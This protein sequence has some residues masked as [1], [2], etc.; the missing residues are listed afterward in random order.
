MKTAIVVAFALSACTWD[1]YIAQP[2]TIGS[3]SDPA[4][5]A[6]LQCDRL[7]FAKGSDGHRLC[8]LREI[9]RLAIV[10]KPGYTPITVLPHPYPP[11]AP[12]GSANPYGITIR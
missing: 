11:L 2:A 4:V 1:E 8:I 9:D 10:P 12:G 7:G 5:H 6:T 3:Q